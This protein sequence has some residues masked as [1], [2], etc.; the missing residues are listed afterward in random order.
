[1]RKKRQRRLMIREWAL[2]LLGLATLAFALILPQ[3]ASAIS[4]KETSVIEHDTITLGDIFTGLESNA[5]K[6]LGAAPQPGSEMTLNARTLMRI[7]VSLD[8][9]W[10]PATTADTVTIRRA[11]TVIERSAIEDAI[12]NEITARG[13]AGQYNLAFAGDVSKIVLPQGETQ[14]VEVVS[15]KMKPGQDQFEAELA[16]P[17]KAHPLKQITVSGRLERL[18]Q[19]P[20]LLSALQNGHVIQENDI[21]TIPMRARD[22][23]DDIVLSKDALIGMTPRRITLAGKP[24]KHIEVQAPQIIERGELVTMVFN[25]GGL[26]LTAQGK[27]MQAGAKGDVIRVVNASSSKTIQGTI[28]GAKEVTVESF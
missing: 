16:A 11:A 25:G 23:T 5:D 24:V 17:S 4:I 13:I 7:A 12:K 18:V 27:A 19:V 10:R 20:V 2:G 22:V 1:M 6:I 9:P 8:L 21:D 26:S 14:S 3:T 28:T 15:L